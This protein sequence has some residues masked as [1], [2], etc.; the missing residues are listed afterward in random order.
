M[1]PDSVHKILSDLKI[2]PWCSIYWSACYRKSTECF[3]S[4]LWNLSRRPPQEQLNKLHNNMTLVVMMCGCLAGLAV[5]GRTM[6]SFIIW[7][8]TIHLAQCR[9]ELQCS[10]WIT[11]WSMDGKLSQK[12]GSGHWQTLF[13]HSRRQLT[14]AIILLTHWLVIWLLCNR[15]ERK[16]V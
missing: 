2:C 5:T 8:P 11:G 16:S 3:L 1:A 9:V 15:T 12:W 4:V 13:H 10:R 6:R 14:E 7:P